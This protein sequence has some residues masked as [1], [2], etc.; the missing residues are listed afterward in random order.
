M[1]WFPYIFMFTVSVTAFI[2]M[3]SF[4]P[5]VPKHPLWSE[6]SY[7]NTAESYFWYLILIIEI[8][9]IPTYLYKY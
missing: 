1:F 8:S 9:T 5:F 6:Q 3:R 7:K 4:A 2:G